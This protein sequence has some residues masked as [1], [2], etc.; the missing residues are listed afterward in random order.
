MTTDY[1][2]VPLPV[3]RRK[4][5]TPAPVSSSAP[6]KPAVR[7]LNQAENAA[8]AARIERG[9]HGGRTQRGRRPVDAPASWSQ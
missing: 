5:H 3:E 1:Q 9:D 2:P 4:M 7:Q 6:G 8:I